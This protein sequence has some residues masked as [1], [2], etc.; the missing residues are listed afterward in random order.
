MKKTS[1]FIA[2][3]FGFVSVASTQNTTTEAQTAALKNSNTALTMA[4]NIDTMILTPQ[5]AGALM[6][7]YEKKAASYIQQ[8]SLEQAYLTQKK[9]TICQNIFLKTTSN[10]KIEETKKSLAI[11]KLQS[12]NKLIQDSIDLK[13]SNLRNYTIFIGLLGLLVVIL[14]FSVYITYKNEHNIAKLNKEITEATAKI[15]V[16]ETELTHINEVRDKLLS[17][18]SHDLRGPLNSMEGVL[19][20]FENKSFSAAETQKYTE[21]IN[22]NAKITTVLVDNIVAWSQ[23]QMN[24]INLVISPFEINE[25]IEN[26]VYLLGL[27]ADNKRIYI[28]NLLKKSVFVN[29]DKD[30]VDILIRNLISNAIKF[31]KAESEIIIDVEEKDGF[32]Q[33]LVQDF[34]LGIAPELQ[35]EIFSLKSGSTVGTGNEKGTG[36]GLVLCKEFATRNG[37]KIWVVSH[38][39]KGSSFYITL[40]LAS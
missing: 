36:L 2:L 28:K 16:Q 1:I 30:T 37:G 13:N 24:G 34:G 11:A 7:V 12:D 40:P 3:I 4:T 8:G 10:Q 22:K 6:V 20:L 29:A 17:V 18:L 31:S 27:I 21:I 32:A 5:N 38:L 26:N 39:G 23:S 9:A 15:I 25:L 19:N 33:I 35:S 14:V